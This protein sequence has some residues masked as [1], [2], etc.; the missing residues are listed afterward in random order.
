MD[1]YHKCN[2]IICNF[3]RK[4]EDRTSPLCEC[5]ICEGKESTTPV[6]EVDFIKQ[7]EGLGII[8]EEGH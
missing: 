4:T 5:P 6:K 8:V 2:N 7:Q 1:Y 3:I